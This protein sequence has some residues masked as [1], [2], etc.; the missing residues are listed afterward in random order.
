M[1]TES[2]ALPAVAVYDSASLWFDNAGSR[3]RVTRFLEVAVRVQ[4]GRRFVSGRMDDSLTASCYGVESMK[5]E[6]I[7]PFMTSLANA[8]DTM[9]NC[10]VHRGQLTFKS[11][12]TPVFEVSGVIGLSGKA[13][14]TVVL[15]LSK[16]VAIK[17]ASTMLMMEATELNSDVVD[18]VGELT[19]MVAGRAKA[20]L[21]HL[22]MSLAL[23]TV[24]TGKNHV[25]SFGSATQTL[26]IPFTCEWGG[27][28]LEVGLI[29]GP[30][31]ME[32]AIAA[33]AAMG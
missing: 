22:A 24:I 5:A 32:A 19:N 30:E 17:A 12:E 21:E 14:G 25:I 31:V 2:W 9:L 23:P 11:A 15:S 4:C 10:P 16:E 26:A 13:V 29:E 1:R 20:A 28:V 18:A 8:F 7:N 6:Y 33:S 3:P 27:A